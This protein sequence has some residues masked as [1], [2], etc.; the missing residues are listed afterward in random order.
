MKKKKL[1]SR[2][3]GFAVWTASVVFAGSALI[4]AVAGAQDAG[5]AMPAAASTAS[6]ATPASATRPASDP[7]AQRIADLHAQLAITSDQEAKWTPFA[8]AMR[9]N[10]DSIR[11]AFKKRAEG[12]NT[13]NAADNMT[14]WAAIAQMHA[15]AMQKLASAFGEVYNSLSADQKA[16]ADA[17]FRA[18]M[19]AHMKAHGQ[20]KKASAVNAVP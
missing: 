10:D 1:A 11:E 18:K 16:K 17:L 13:M 4:P 5:Q 7:V 3:R 19:K 14:S 8:Q 15:Q 2:S 12:V 6:G 20:H 9:D